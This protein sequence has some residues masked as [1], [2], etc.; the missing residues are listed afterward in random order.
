MLPIIHST[1]YLKKY[2]ISKAI[3][4]FF[5]SHRNIRKLTA[6][7]AILIK[8]YQPNEQLPSNFMNVDMTV[9]IAK[10]YIVAMIYT[11]V[12]II[13]SSKLLSALITL[14]TIQISEQ[15]HS[16]VEQLILAQ[17]LHDHLLQTRDL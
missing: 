15:Y 4:S 5:L 17:Y 6:T 1:L 12:H 10:C 3:L 11:S 7:N 2:C 8:I 14:V 16:N 9:F 13:Q